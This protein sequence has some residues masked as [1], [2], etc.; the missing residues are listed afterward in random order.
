[1]IYLIEMQALNNASPRE[2]VTLRF[3]TGHGY[4]TRP[5]ETPA[6]TPYYPYILQPG[7]TK[8]TCFSD[9]TTSGQNV[10]SRGEIVL[11]NND[12][13]LDYLHEY[14][15]AGRTCLIYRG[16]ESAAYPSGFALLETQILEQ[17]DLSF[18]EIIFPL[19]D[20][21]KLLD[22][23]LQY[24]KYAGTNILPNGL[25][26]DIS[27][28]GKP[29]PLC[30]GQVL[31]CSV[32]CVNTS[33]LIYQCHDG[34]VNSSD[35][36]VKDMGVLLIRGYD[37]TSISD[38]ETNAPSAGECRW[39]LA[40]GYFRLGSMPVGT[41]T[42]NFSVGTTA[43]STAAQIT[44]AIMLRSGGAIVSS[45]ISA[46]DVT[47]LD[48]A[49]SSI[50]GIWVSEETQRRELVSQILDTVGAW[51][52]ADQYGLFRMQRWEL[53][54]GTPVATLGYNNIED[55]MTRLPSNDNGQGVAAGKISIQYD[56]NYTVQGD[57]EL[58]GSVSL[59]YKTWAANEYRIANVLIS[60]PNVLAP[61]ELTFVS[62]FVLCS[63][64]LTES[65]RRA[66]LYG[67]ERVFY[68]V[69]VID[70][71][72][73]PLISQGKC[74]LL[75]IPRFGMNTGKLFRIAAYQA[76]YESDTVELTLWG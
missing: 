64:A 49:N 50:L 61:P 66:A 9:R 63:D 54:S 69:T 30:F 28:A 7:L 56:K 17:P 65:N 48:S 6:S 10:I 73:F 19:R 31:N 40:N 27:L 67:V 5:T 23:P 44:K 75:Q 45:D 76:D 11:V 68:S 4:I 8:V 21:S 24:D 70:P 62:N 29:K 39:Y 37:Y 15:F 43:Q 59:A 38:M 14:D 58:A 32:P 35:L 22:I 42:A 34:V 53:P 26:G 46:A 3:C 36:V 25:E 47:A 1:M 57:T 16:E 52:G 12:G 74:V 13:E 2:V 51:W 18:G 60:Q 72:I 55:S 33:R 41:I 20:K 71:D